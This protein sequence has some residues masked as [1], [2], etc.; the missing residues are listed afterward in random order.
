MKSQH[1]N[2]C[3]RKDVLKSLAVVF[4]G[5]FLAWSFVPQDVLPPEIIAVLG[6]GVAMSICSFKGIRVL[7]KMDLR[8]A[9]T[10][11]S[12]LFVAEVI[13]QTGF[14][15]MIAGFLQENITNQ[16]ALIIVIMLITA[17]A[18]GCFSAGPAAAAM[19]PI[20]VNICNG[21]LNGQSDWIA[22][23]YAAAICAGSSLFMWSATA[24]FILSGKINEAVLTGDDNSRISWGCA[25][26]WKYGFVNFV[27]QLL[28][29]ISM[30]ALVL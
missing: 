28:I 3:V 10:I 6:Y 11:A 1:K 16:K 26:Y 14:L 12:F 15:N 17:I 18:A 13:S 4:V 24:G 30:V 2:I 19:M 23:A 9:L 21:P 5:M 29:A 25:Q 20:I 27:V 8:S 7:Q 22:V